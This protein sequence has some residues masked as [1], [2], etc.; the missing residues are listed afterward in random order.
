[1]FFLQ[2]SLNLK[3]ALSLPPSLCLV[4]KVNLKEELLSCLAYIGATS[5]KDNFGAN[6]YLL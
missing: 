3:S 1:M 6:T 2:C 4:W 5:L